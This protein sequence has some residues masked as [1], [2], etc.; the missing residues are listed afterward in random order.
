ERARSDRCLSQGH[1]TQDRHRG[2]VASS[3]GSAAAD[4][5]FRKNK[6]RAGLAAAVSKPRR[7][8]RER[9]EVASTIPE[10]LRRLKKKAP[11]NSSATAVP[12]AA[13]LVVT[14]V[15]VWANAVTATK[16]QATAN[17][18]ANLVCF[19]VVLCFR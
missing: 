11:A 5:V 9:V 18:F 17:I 12:A 15:E 10:G 2:K 7:D 6:T 3:G 4:R 1:G 16:P 19:I 13:S 14:V 8:Y